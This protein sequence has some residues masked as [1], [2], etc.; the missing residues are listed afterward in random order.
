MQEVVDLFQ[1]SL[2]LLRDI[3]QDDGSLSPQRGP[4]VM[5]LSLLVMPNV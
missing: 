3:L 1:A 5:D 2:R 4:D